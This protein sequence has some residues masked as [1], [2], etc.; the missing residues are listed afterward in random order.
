[1]NAYREQGETEPDTKP[2]RKLRWDKLLNLG[3][4]E[5]YEPETAFGFIAKGIAWV[6]YVVSGIFLFVL[7]L[8]ILGAISLGLF[9]LVI[10]SIKYYVG[11]IIF[12]ALLIWSFAHVLRK[13]SEGD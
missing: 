5:A 9:V 7:A 10:Y 6:G 13:I 2:K 1:M 3:N 12:P 4:I 11:F 8:G